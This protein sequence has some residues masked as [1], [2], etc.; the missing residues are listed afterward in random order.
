[1]PRI[2]PVSIENAPEASQPVLEQIKSGLGKVPNLL[3]TFG[4]SPAALHSYV[5]QKE[6]LKKGSLGDQFGESIAIAMAHFNKCG[7]CASA[8]EVIGKMSGLSDDE[9]ALNRNGKASDPKVQAGIDL[10][11]A[12][13]EAKGFVSDEAFASA[14]E[15]G[16]S[17]G[18]VLEVLAITMFNMYTNYANHMLETEN[19]FPAVELNEAVA[20]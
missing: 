4:R 5:L 10:A 18:D 16:L 1:M 13:V 3:S 8:H 9:R 6:A 15:G 7:Y 2:E 17:D 19:D 20:V 11:R 14:R 12:L